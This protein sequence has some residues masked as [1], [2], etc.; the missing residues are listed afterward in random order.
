MTNLTLTGNT[1]PVQW[2]SEN[3]HLGI[4]FSNFIDASLNAT[5]RATFY[6]TESEQIENSKRIHSSLMSFDRG[7]YAISLLLPGIT[8]YTVQ[9]GTANLLSHPV[10]RSGLL[11]AGEEKNLI[12]WLAGKLPA[13]RMLKLFIGLKENRI[14]NSRTRSIILG[15]I[16]NSPKIEFRAV[17]Y[18]TKLMACLSHAWGRRQS[19]ILVSILKKDESKRN[20]KEKKLIEKYIDRYMENINDKDKIYQCIRFIFRDEEN[21]S[22]K[23]LKAYAEAKKKIEAG[24]ILPYEVL[25]GI[26]SV[27]HPDISN[28]EVLKF[29]KST[30]TDNQKITLQRKAKEANVK[31]DFNPEKFDAVKLYLYAYEMGMTEKI[32]KVLCDKAEKATFLFNLEDKKAGILIDCSQSMR[33]PDTQKLRPMATAL[34]VR[35]VLVRSAKESVIVYSG[36]NEVDENDMIIPAGST[37]LAKGLI[38]LMMQEPDVIFILSD[39]YENSP[40]GR[41]SE[42][43]RKSQKIGINIPIIQYSPVMA[44]E[45]G[46]IRKLA[47]NIKAMPISTPE[48]S[49]IGLLKEAFASDPENGLKILKKIV[50]PNLI[51]ARIDS[52]KLIGEKNELI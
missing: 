18:R 13:Q 17:K 40:S 7:I 43:I 30:L 20:S 14:N 48:T 29:S 9:L 1:N 52:R 6:N 3:D 31:V 26:R 47:E 10:N 2:S 42:V 35:D 51:K 4:A 33:G 11:T 45:A 8:D 12:L 16:L 38:E 50:K 36:E 23:T 37:D 49:A 25:E 21:I 34:A 24:R 32:K 19:S 15:S 46:G 5:S 39:G 27:Y 22:L 41:M 44:A 28:N